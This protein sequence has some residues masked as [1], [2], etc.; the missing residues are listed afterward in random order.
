[1]LVEKLEHSLT[2]YTII[3]LKCIKDL[4]VKSAYYKTLSGKHR[5]NT[6]T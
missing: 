6:L 3:N 4:N 1:M 2:P 5:W